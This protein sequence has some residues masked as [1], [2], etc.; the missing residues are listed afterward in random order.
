MPTTTYQDTTVA[1]SA[2]GARTDAAGAAVTDYT[3]EEARLFQSIATPGWVT[4]GAFLVAQQTVPAM[5]VKVGSGTAKADLYIVGGTVAGQ[6][7]YLARL[8]VTSVTVTIGAADVSQPRTDEIYL[9]VL[10]NT[11]DST[12]RGLPRIGYRKGDLGGANPGPDTAWKASV[13]LARVA[14]AANASTIVAANITDLRA[15]TRLAPAFGGSAA[16]ISLTY[17]A[18]VNT[19]ASVGTYFRVTATGNFTL[20]IPTNPTDGQTVT[21]EVL[22]SGADRTA[23]L[24][25]GSA[26]AFLF[27]TDIPSLSATTSAK[28]DLI[29]AIYNSAAGRWLVVGYVKGF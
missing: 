8:D 21:W 24:T 19:D 2:V 11:Y 17:G 22:A 26:G 7:N 20:A 16:P 12:A 18:T 25:T 29:R 14:V 15:P 4:T 27:G 5:S 23:S 28:R 13:L 9:V 10:D 1:V 6:G 3:A